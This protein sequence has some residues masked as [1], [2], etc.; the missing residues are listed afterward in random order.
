MRFAIEDLIS[1]LVGEKS[2][3]NSTTI[4]LPIAIIIILSLDKVNGQI[5]S[6]MDDMGLG[7]CMEKIEAKDI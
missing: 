6:D 2:K 7:D 1:N 5:P 4:Y 3:F